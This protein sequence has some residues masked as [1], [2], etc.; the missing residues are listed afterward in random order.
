MVA[1]ADVAIAAPKTLYRFTQA[2]G[3]DATGEFVFDSTGAM[4][5]TA[6]GASG[7]G[8]VFK[9][10]GNTHS[11]TVLYNFRGGSTDGAQP[12]P[13]IVLT[14]AGL[15]YGTTA[16][17]G[18]H[19]L[20]TIFQVNAATGAEAVDY[21]FSGTPDAATPSTGLVQAPNGLLYGTAGFGGAAKAGAIFSFVPAS[22][23][24]AVVSSFT[25]SYGYVLPNSLIAGPGGVLYGATYKGGITD[26]GTVFALQTSSGVGTQIYDFAAAPD[27][28]SNP[29]PAL[30][31]DAKGRLY[32]T[33]A[34]RQSA[35]TVFR[36]VPDSGKLGVLGT[37]KGS[38]STVT[39][40]LVAGTGTL[41][42][43]S[44][45]ATKTAGGSLFAVSLAT[46]GI[47][48]LYDFPAV[49]GVA[50]YPAGLV[51]APKGVLIGSTVRPIGAVCGTLFA[52]KP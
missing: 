31:I 34:N 28:L 44:Y 16:A 17:G 13:G 19:N 14:N 33:A 26:A 27:G 20:G 15:L 51:I 2:T 9:Y 35:G 25:G 50:D 24:E 36:L 46:G 47:T 38:Q 30:A 29:G 6:G 18:A 42:G 48:T 41:Y 8:I 10:V 40:L 11:F 12:L 7:N 37:L 23:A 1:L 32:G 22:Q 43:T 52:F 49:R 21:S 45:L 5:G 39:G 3:F 4:Y